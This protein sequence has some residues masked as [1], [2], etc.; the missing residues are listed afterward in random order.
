MEKEE[1]YLVLLE[2]T[3]GM[4]L[5]TVSGRNRNETKSTK[6]KPYTGIFAYLTIVIGC[7]RGR[8]LYP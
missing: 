2:Y 6:M 4:C 7:W 1:L 5:F 8:Y 3:A